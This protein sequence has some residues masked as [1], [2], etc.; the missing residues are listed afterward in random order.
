[1]VADIIDIMGV[2]FANKI[3]SQKYDLNL[4]YCFNFTNS[5]PIEMIEKMIKSFNKCSFYF[6]FSEYFHKDSIMKT[7]NYLAEIFGYL[8]RYEEKIK[9]S[10]FIMKGSHKYTSLYTKLEKIYPGLVFKNHRAWFID[11]PFPKKSGNSDEKNT[12]IFG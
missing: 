1:M 7:Y 12:L 6:I 5:Q 4:H 10:L 8:R 2:K 9:L 3:F 11:A